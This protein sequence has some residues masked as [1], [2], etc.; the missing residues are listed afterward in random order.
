VG[1][2]NEQFPLFASPPVAVA[3]AA[4]VV[5][6]ERISPRQ[7]PIVDRQVSADILSADAL[8]LGAG[9]QLGQ[10]ANPE[11]HAMKRAEAGR[12]ESE[13]DLSSMQ[14][15][16][17]HEMGGSFSGM[18]GPSDEHDSPNTQETKRRELHTMQTASKVVQ[19]EEGAFGQNTKLS[20]IRFHGGAEA[21]DAEAP[22]GQ[23]GEMMSM[24]GGIEEI[25][26]AR[27]ES[28]H[29]VISNT[30]QTRS[31]ALIHMESMGNN[32]NSNRQ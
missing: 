12:M 16:R 30:D 6:S 15:I 3:T 27:G 20:P 23:A 11:W 17:G 13:R 32:L 31:A 9:A 25:P 10:A 24:P 29:N 4:T 21:D 26:M 5:P 1:A 18:R 22:A 2:G 14:T 19:D 8:G 7:A 28:P